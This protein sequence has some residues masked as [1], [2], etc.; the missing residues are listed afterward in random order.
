MGEQLGGRELTLCVGA[1]AHQ[2]ADH[3]QQERPGFPAMTTRS[4][5]GGMENNW[6]STTNLQMGPHAP[7]PC[8]LIP[9]S[10]RRSSSS[11]HGPLP[12]PA[13]PRQQPAPNRFEKA[14][15]QTKSFPQRIDHWRV[16]RLRARRTT[17]SSWPIGRRLP[18]ASGARPGRQV[19]MHVTA[20]F[21]GC[22]AL[23]V[24]LSCAHA[25]LAGIK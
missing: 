20:S 14:L 8:F 15:A 7:Y 25:M 17:A 11:V 3:I 5:E 13:Q 6:S 12:I 24:L 19:G 2:P 22:T 21:L 10:S 18:Q 9:S 16:N 23:F 4:C 1:R